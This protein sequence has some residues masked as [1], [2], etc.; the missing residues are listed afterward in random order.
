MACLPFS[1][2]G[3]TATRPGR[4]RARSARMAPAAPQQGRLLLARPIPALGGAG[5]APVLHP[6]L[7][8]EGEHPG[9]MRLDGSYNRPRERCREARS[10]H[11]KEIITT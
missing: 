3:R 8:V 11:R 10:E 2:L 1:T 5:A 7:E 4:G 6:R 9:K